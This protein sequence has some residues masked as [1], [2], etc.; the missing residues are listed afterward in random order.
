MPYPQKFVVLFIVASFQQLGNGSNIDCRTTEAQKAQRGN[1]R[2]SS[3]EYEPQRH[4]GTK[5]AIAT[6][7]HPSAF[8]I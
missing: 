4:K 5:I 2:R 3:V 1:Y 8:P 6:H 7:L